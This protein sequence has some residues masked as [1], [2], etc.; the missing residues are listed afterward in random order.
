MMNILLT[1]VSSGI[2]AATARQLLDR[3]HRV[4]GTVRTLPVAPELADHPNFVGLTLDVTDRASVRR[5]VGELAGAGRPL[6]AVVNNAGVA[7][8]GPLETLA[9]EDYRWQ[10]DVNLFGTLAV[11][12]EALPLLHAAR[13]GGAD[14]VKIVNVSSVSG[15]VTAPYT[16]IYSASKFALE[17]LTDGLR[18]ELHAF[19]IDVISVAPGPVRTPIWEKAKTQTKAF[20][21]TR[22][23]HVL[24]QLVPYV[25]AAAA[26]GVEPARVARLIADTLE[27]ERPRPDRLIMN[28]AWTLRLVRKLPKRW[29]DRLFLRNMARGTRY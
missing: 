5:A 2:G 3:G 19:G 13:A 7:V 22:Y 16:S 25:E 26:G 21:G 8:A 6:H 4:Y 27:A 20:V 24:D 28:K 9:E 10:F 1:G 18:R 14:N 29:Q 23:A 15:Y 11:C 12:Q 17:A